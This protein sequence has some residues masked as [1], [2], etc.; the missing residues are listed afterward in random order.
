[1][2]LQPTIKIQQDIQELIYQMGGCEH[3]SHYVTFDFPIDDATPYIEVKNGKYYY[4]I[5][6]REE[7]Y[8][9]RATRDYQELLYWN[10]EY[11]SS[12]IASDYE[13]KHRQ[14]NVDSRRLYFKTQLGLLN[15]IN[16]MFAKR[17]RKEREN[18]LES[19]PF[20]DGGPNCID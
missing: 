13:M 12:C 4:I 18:I 14:P 6:E 5:S 2:G 11:I 7:E 16:P 15:Q 20:R 19:H 1:M 17:C 8:E 9:R 3:V 10:A